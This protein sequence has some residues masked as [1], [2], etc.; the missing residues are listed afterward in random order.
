MQQ[1]RT[2]EVLARELDRDRAEQRSRPRGRRQG[3]SVVDVI[4]PL[5]EVR[6]PAGGRAARGIPDVS[7]T[8]RGRL[9][10]CIRRA[11]RRPSTFE[12]TGGMA[13]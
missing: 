3:A 10:W 13:R 9:V 5:R 1:S 2:I 4:S 11:L 6:P 7:A 8:T 12:P